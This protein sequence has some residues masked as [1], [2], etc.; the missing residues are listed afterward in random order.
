MAFE[1][2]DS[3]PGIQSPV[4][5]VVA[6]ELR[7][8]VQDVVLGEVLLLVVGL[9]LSGGARRHEEGHLL[10]GLALLLLSSAAEVLE[11]VHHE[12]VVFD[13]FLVRPLLR[14][15]A[16]VALSFHLYELF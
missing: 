9:A 16:I 7:Q 13:L 8:S 11:T 14:P 1:L 10:E 3:L 2:G 15:P 4:F 12:Q 6:Y 5:V